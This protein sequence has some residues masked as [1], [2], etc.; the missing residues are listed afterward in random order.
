M[1]AARDGTTL[2]VAV[3]CR[4]CRLD[5]LIGPNVASCYLAYCQ[6]HSFAEIIRELYGEAPTGRELSDER[7][8]DR[9]MVRNPLE[10]R[11]RED[12]IERTGL[13]PSCM[14]AISN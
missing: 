5:E 1:R 9:L 14:L 4:S 13:R 7:R 6:M 10:C 3:G 11:T 2:V 12:H 8:K